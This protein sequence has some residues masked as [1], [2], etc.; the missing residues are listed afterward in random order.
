[1]YKNVVF[2]FGNVLF[3][4]NLG[5]IRECFEELLGEQEAQKA[6]EL[7]DG[8]QVFKTY[9]VGGMST[10]EFVE[11]IRLS[12][13]EN[14]TADNVIASWNSIF[15]EMPLRRFEFLEALRKNYRVFLLSN[16]NQLHEDYVANYMKTSHGISDFESRYFDGVY[17]SHHIRLRK[18]MPE[19][20]EYVLAD[21]EI[22]AH[23]TVFFDDLTENIEAANDI[24]IKGI[25]KPVSSEVIEMARELLDF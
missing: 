20:Y 13:P 12:S 22:K 1:M 24:G 2:D 17:Y 11:A 7:L 16:I 18:P 8:Q 25:H 3:D 21:A 9:E 19:I 14:L 15:K 23:E 6:F 4:L 5:R 10:E